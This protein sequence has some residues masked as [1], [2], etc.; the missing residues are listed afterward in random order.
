MLVQFVI[1]LDTRVF[2][3]CANGRRDFTLQNQNGIR[4]VACWGKVR[5]ARS[6]G[7]ARQAW[8]GRSFES[9]GPSWLIAEILLLCDGIQP[10]V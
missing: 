10:V 6:L 1:G 3:G 8:R 2:L 9:T 5:A 4:T 7:W